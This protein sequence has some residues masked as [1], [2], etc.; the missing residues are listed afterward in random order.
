MR[1]QVIL[2]MTS[3]FVWGIVH[4]DSL[5]QEDPFKKTISVQQ[6]DSLIILYADSTNF[7]ILDVRTPG[8]YTNGFIEG[9]TNLDYYSNGFSD[10][11]N[12]LDKSKVYLVYCMSGGRSNAASNK[13]RDLQFKYIYNMNGGLSAWIAAGFPITTGTKNWQ[14]DLVHNQIKFYPNPATLESAFYLSQEALEEQQISIMNAM[15]QQITR[16]VMSQGTQKRVDLNQLAPGLY[17]YAVT[18]NGMLT[19]VDRLLIQ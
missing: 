7:S 2:L 18:K 6:A 14:I 4:T 15:G 13:M 5:A 16:F 1:K 10:S 3:F 12:T 17:Y 19:Q 8:E 11:L 9:A